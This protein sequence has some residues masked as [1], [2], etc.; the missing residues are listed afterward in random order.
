MRSL[1]AREIL[2]E[3]KK[4]NGLPFTTRWLTKKYGVA[5]TNLAIREMNKAGMLRLY[6][7][8]PDTGKGLVSQA[9]HSVY[10]DDEPI[11]LTQLK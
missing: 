8:L 5:K 2:K 3:V 7:P 1:F 11:I 6:P 9:E 4:Y 10:V